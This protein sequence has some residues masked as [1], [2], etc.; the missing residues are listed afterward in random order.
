MAQKEPAP[1]IPV[2]AAA[3][4]FQEL[5]KSGLQKS[6]SKAFWAK[7]SIAIAACT[8]ATEPIRQK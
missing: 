8:Y 1:Q 3:E 7:E 2:V 4:V 5:R 6:L